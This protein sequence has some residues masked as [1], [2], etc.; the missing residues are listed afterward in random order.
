MKYLSREYKLENFSYSFQMPLSVNSFS[1]NKNPF[2]SYLKLIKSSIKP[3]E[4]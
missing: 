4:V 1:E 3:I 2:K